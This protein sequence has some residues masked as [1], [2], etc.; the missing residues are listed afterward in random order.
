MT[1]TKHVYADTHKYICMCV[2]VCMLRGIYWIG[3]RLDSPPMA[4]CTLKRQRT[5]FPRISEKFQSNTEVWKPLGKL[6][7]LSQC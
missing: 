2:C 7:L 6:W 4:V 5:R 1:R 3:K